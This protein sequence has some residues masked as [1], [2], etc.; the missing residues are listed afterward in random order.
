MGIFNTNRMVDGIF[1]YYKA[2]EQTKHS[3]L[4]KM[5]PLFFGFCG[6]FD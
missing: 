5:F 6:I 4:V 2:K 3:F 1:L